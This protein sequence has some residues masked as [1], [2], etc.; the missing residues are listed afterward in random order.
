[1]EYINTSL[2]PSTRSLW[3]ATISRDILAHP[4]IDSLPV[5]T[6]GVPFQYK[7]RLSTYE[8]TASNCWA[9][10]GP[11]KFTMGCREILLS[12]TWG[13]LYW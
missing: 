9:I 5:M 7:D 6:G 1:M 2:Y 4:L 8:P 11:T 3:P 10:V 12:L 13:S